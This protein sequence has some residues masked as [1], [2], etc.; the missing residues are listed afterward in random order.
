MQAL[1]WSG[2]SDE[3]AAVFDSYLAFCPDEAR[4]RREIEILRQSR[5][6]GRLTSGRFR[7]HTEMPFMAPLK[8]GDS[9]DG[10]IDLAAFDLEA[11]TWIV[12]DWKTNKGAG[13]SDLL[14]E[15]RAQ[16]IA[17]RDCL[18]ALVQRPVAGA[19]YATATGEE[20]EAA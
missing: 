13:A 4:G 15:Y 19:L 18:A 9:V 2:T 7:V 3:R 5:L 17:Y 8:G 16:L 12:V 6:F 14:A 11:E 20:V 10:I 1:P